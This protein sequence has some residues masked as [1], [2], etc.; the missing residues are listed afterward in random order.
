[1]FFWING[2]IRQQQRKY[3]NTTMAWIPLGSPENTEDATKPSI[4]A[5]RASQRSGWSHYCRA[6]RLLRART[7]DT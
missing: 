3:N 6:A 1:M 7:T 4:R 2:I 5:L